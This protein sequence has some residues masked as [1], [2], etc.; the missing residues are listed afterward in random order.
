MWFELVEALAT[1]QPHFHY[2]SDRLPSRH[3]LG[4]FAGHHHRHRRRN[5]TMQLEAH[6]ISDNCNQSYHDHPN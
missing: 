5:P 2:G 4:R 1:R 3:L 6:S